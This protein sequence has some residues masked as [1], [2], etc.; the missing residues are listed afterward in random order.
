MRRRALKTDMP[1]ITLVVCLY[2]EADLL[3]R[4]IERTQGCYDEL[5]V[6]H[7]GQDTMGTRAIVE[8]AGGRFFERPRAFQQEPHWP[9]AWG[10]AKHDWIL[11]MDAD[12]APSFALAEW[13]KNFR[14]TPET[15]ADVSGY[16]CVWPLWNGKRQVA[17]HWPGNRIFLLHRQRVRFIGMAEQVPVPDG[18]WEK[19][20]L[21]LEHRPQ[22][23]SYGLRYVFTRP[24]AANWRRVIAESLLPD[25]PAHLEQWRWE[26]RPWPE[27]WEVVRT[28]PVRTALIRVLWWFPC[29]LIEQWRIEGRPFPMAVL[30]PLLMQSLIC[31]KYI[32]LRR[33]KRR[34]AD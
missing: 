23:L 31:L 2:N 26:K 14:V 12:E 4:L 7:D 17:S 8:A 29:S 30:T 15:V 6:V 11:R 3:Q 33:Q 28:R 16:T 10:E 19:L 24:Q 5:I 9:F 13:L 32:R 1:A 18:R 20:S 27:A 34:D 25:T 21:V 22:R